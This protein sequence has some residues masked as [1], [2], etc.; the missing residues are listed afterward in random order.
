MSRIDQ[1]VVGL[2]HED[3]A[4]NEQC[5]LPF[6]EPPIPP[7]T[8]HGKPPQPVW[9]KVRLVDLQA[10]DVVGDFEFDKTVPG[11]R[12]GQRCSAICECGYTGGVGELWFARVLPP[13]LPGQSD[14]VV[15]TK[16]YRQR[17]GT[18]AL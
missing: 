18:L 11:E 17:T 5:V 15:Q 4:D 3:G 9:R 2:G 14:H 12:G 7:R 10:P 16:A 13:A 6:V 1:N 8:C